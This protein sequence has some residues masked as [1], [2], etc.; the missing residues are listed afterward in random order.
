MAQRRGTSAGTES[1]SA[2]DLRRLPAAGRAGDSRLWLA[3]PRR[4]ARRFP[5][6]RHRRYAMLSVMRSRA[7]RHPARQDPREEHFRIASHLEGL[8][9]FLRYLPPAMRRTGAPRVVLYVHGATF[10]SALSVA[11]RFDGRSWRDE[12]ADAGFHVWGFDFLGFGASD[13]YPEMAEP[14]QANPPLCDAQDASAQLAAAARFI[15]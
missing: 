2:D 10:P 3:R 4:G 11:H 6:S 13:R 14:A 1:R 7:D 8:A 12:L 9:L 5:H 15:L